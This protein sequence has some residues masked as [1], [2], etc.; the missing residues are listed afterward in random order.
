[1]IRDPVFAED[2]RDRSPHHEDA[3]VEVMG[4]RLPVGVGL[5]L[6]FADLVA[7]PD[8]LG[9]EFGSGHR[10]LL[11]SVGRRSRIHARTALT[12]TLWTRRADDTRQ[13]CDEGSHG[14][15][16]T[17]AHLDVGIPRPPPERDRPS[18]PLANLRHIQGAEAERLIVGV[19]RIGASFF[20]SHHTLEY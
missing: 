14:L 20:L 2:E 3:R 11:A 17:P 12:R 9:L 19:P 8:E 15:I 6:A 10:A 1:T 5:D 16:G 4:V 7:F 18:A 13:R